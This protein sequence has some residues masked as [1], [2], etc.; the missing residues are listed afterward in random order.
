MF[1]V[2]YHCEMNV[3]DN[4]EQVENDRLNEDYTCENLVVY[5]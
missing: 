2:I 3:R 4:D 1:H 5:S